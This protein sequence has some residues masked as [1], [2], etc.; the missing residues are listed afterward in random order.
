MDR[1]K[2]IGRQH[3]LEVQSHTAV[4]IISRFIMFITHSRLFSDLD[5]IA[6]SGRRPGMII[7]ETDEY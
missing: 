6:I 5:Q 2:G 1:L 3:I 7:A 4:R